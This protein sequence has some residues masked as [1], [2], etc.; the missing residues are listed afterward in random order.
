M[1]DFIISAAN[2]ILYLLTKY[3][4]IY[5]EILTNVLALWEWTAEKS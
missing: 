5:E 2:I 3:P 1:T 4:K